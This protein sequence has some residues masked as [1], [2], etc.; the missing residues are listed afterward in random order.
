MEENMFY[1]MSQKPLPDESDSSFSKTVIVY[2]D[3]DSAIGFGYYDFEIDEWLHSGDNSFLLKCWCY[4]PVP[5]TAHNHNW[6]PVAPKGY[7]K[8]LF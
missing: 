4:I 2:S 5:D 1:P 3:N 8:S 6:I 7:L